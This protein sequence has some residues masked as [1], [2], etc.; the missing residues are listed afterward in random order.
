MK[1]LILTLCLAASLPALADNVYR[2]VDQSGHV[3]FSDQPPPPQVKKSSQKNYNAGTIDS[4]E[5]YSVRVAREKFPVTLYSSDS[6]CG[7]ACD[8]AKQL[9]DNRG[10]PYTL[11]NVATDADSQKALHDL[12]G[13]I[14]IPTLVV[15]SQNLVGFADGPWNNLLDMAGYPKKITGGKATSNSPE[16]PDN[17]QS[18][19]T[20]AAERQ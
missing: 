15:G 12:I 16:N 11:K 19:E 4:G 8:M 20:P 5:S 6:T 9:L 3:H 7:P 14:Q 17:L 13:K 18:P 2:W 1:T 10:I